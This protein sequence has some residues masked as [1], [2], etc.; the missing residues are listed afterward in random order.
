MSSLRLT[1]PQQRSLHEDPPP[2]LW[3]DAEFFWVMKT[4]YAP[5]AYMCLHKKL[6]YIP[7]YHPTGTS[8]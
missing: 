8:K 7:S 2:S 3:D 6:V 5:S 1:K 4:S